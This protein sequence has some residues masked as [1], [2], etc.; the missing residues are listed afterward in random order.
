MSDLAK[1]QLELIGKP[2][3]QRFVTLYKD[4]AQQIDASAGIITRA[5]ASQTLTLPDANALEQALDSVAE[6]TLLAGDPLDGWRSTNFDDAFWTSA[7]RGIHEQTPEVNPVGQ[8]FIK[9]YWLLYW[10]RAITL[11]EAAR[12]LFGYPR[13][14]ALD[15]AHYMRLYTMLFGS[16]Q[17]FR[18]FVNPAE[19]NTRKAKCV[20]E[21]EV[22]DFIRDNG[23]LTVKKHRRKTR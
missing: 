8:L 7:L 20:L 15:T 5:N 11:T 22:E 14:K 1:R 12:L 4:Y 6:F 3:L 9:G 23:F 19:E 2:K 21:S 18:V 17:A 13:G 16:K 10:N